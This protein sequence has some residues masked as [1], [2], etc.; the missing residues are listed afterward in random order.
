MGI[1]RSE[2]EAK[3]LIDPMRREIL[4]LLAKE[5]LTETQLAKML[6]L[7]A[8]SVDYH[9]KGLKKGNFVSVAG[10]EAEGH[11]IIQKFYQANARAYLVEKEKMPLYIKRYFMPMDIERA[12][13]IA[14]CLTLFKASGFKLESETMES[15]AESLANAISRTAQNFQYPRLGADPEPAISQLYAEALG[16]VLRN[17]F[18]DLGQKILKL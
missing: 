17:E 15:L 12:R 14:A 3:L 18:K 2:A 13:G 10:R 6:G 16:Q 5:A 1:V 4:R 8:P 11:G 9:L 7:S